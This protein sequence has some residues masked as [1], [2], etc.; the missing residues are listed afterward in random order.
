VLIVGIPAPSTM[1]A[2]NLLGTAGLV[3]VTV[4]VGGLTGSV[5]WSLLTGSVIAVV[6]AMIASTHE[7]AQHPPPS[8]PAAAA[9]QPGPASSP[10]PTR[11]ARAA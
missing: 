5:W 3:G 8:V 1:L 2:A 11:T 7:T 6:L 10:A 4:A 9:G